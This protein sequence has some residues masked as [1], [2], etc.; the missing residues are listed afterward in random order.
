V[1]ALV[2]AL[3]QA[4][5]L[6][7]GLVLVL[8]L[9]LVLGLGLGLGLGTA[10]PLETGRV[11][12]PARRSRAPMWLRLRWSRRRRIRPW[13]WRQRRRS[14]DARSRVVENRSWLLRGPVAREV[15]QSLASAV[16][17]QMA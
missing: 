9:V 13:S 1:P 4:S 14:D 8:V 11:P 16:R 2:P 17:E 15:W 3:V 12:G 10:R 7:L 5:V 6:V